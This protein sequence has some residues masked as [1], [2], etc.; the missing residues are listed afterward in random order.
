L[1]PIVRILTALPALSSSRIWR[2]ASRRIVALK[3]PA[4]PRSPVI[5]TIATARSSSWRCRSGRPRSEVEA[6]AVPTISSIIRSAYGRISR[7]RCSE[8]RSR[9]AATISIARVI[10]R[11]LRTARRR[12]RMS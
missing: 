6:R 12:R 8:R 7:M 1:R 2:R 3:P 11:V 5:G 10:F 9:A 4:R